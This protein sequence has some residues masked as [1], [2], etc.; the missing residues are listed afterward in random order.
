VHE[1]AEAYLRGELKIPDAALAEWQANRR[2]GGTFIDDSRRLGMIVH[3]TLGPEFFALG[4]ETP[5][6]R[7]DSLQPRGNAM[8]VFAPGRRFLPTPPVPSEHIE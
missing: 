2:L 5:K 6:L 4:D 1:V 8:R 3:P 7:G